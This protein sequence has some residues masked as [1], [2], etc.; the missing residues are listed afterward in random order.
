MILGARIR[1]D[2]P[3]LLSERCLNLQDGESMDGQVPRR[4]R[5]PPGSKLEQLE[6]AQATRLEGRLEVR[7]DRRA[8]DYSRLM[9]G[10]AGS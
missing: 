6:Q 4:H 3:L 2:L 1:W 9:R 5:G 8:L 7:P 10:E